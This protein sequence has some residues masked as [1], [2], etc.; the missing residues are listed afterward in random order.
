MMGRGESSNYRQNIRSYNSMFA[1]TSMGGHIDHEINRQGGGPYVFRMNGQNYHQIGTLL[2]KEGHYP[3]FAQLYIYDTENEVKNRLHASTSKTNNQQLDENIV[4]GLLEMLDEN[5]V[6]VKTFRMARDRFKEA[7]FQNVQIR[8]L[9]ER[10]RDGRRY[11]LPTTSEVAA[12]ILGQQTDEASERDIIVEHKDKQ[13]QRISELHPSFMSMQYPLLFPYGE[14]GF[15]A[16]IPYEQKKGRAGKRKYVTMLEYYCCRIQQRLNQST[17]LLR[18]G[19]LFLQFIVDAAACIEQWRLN[20]YRMHQGTLRTEL[21]SGLQDAMDNGD[22][23]TDQVGKKIILPSSYTNSP[24]N[25]QQY[26]QDAMAICRWAGYPDLFITFTCNPKWPEIQYMM[27]YI[28]EQKLEDRPD[29]CNRVFHI[30]L[31]QL[32]TK[33]IKKNMCFGRT[34]AVVYTVELQKRGL[35]H[36]HI[37]VFLDP[38]DRDASPSNIDRIISAE[39]P[40]INEDPEGYTAVEN[41]MMHGPCG[42]ANH[43]SPCMIDGKCSKH[44]PKLFSQETTIDEEGY[45]VYRRRDDSRTVEKDGVRLDNRYVVPYNRNLIVKYQA[46]INVEWCNKSRSIKYLFKYIHKGDDRTTAKL[47]ATDKNDEIQMYLDA[48]Y[49]SAGEASWRIFGFELQHREPSVQRL[50]F[51]L[52]NEQVVVFPDSTDLEQIVYKPGIET[53]I[54]TEWMTANR[55]YLH[56]RDLTYAEFPTKWTWHQKEKEW[57]PRSGGKRSIGRIYYAHPASG[58]RYY[59]RILL[60]MMKGCKS[61]KDIRTVNGVVHQTYKSACYALGLLD[62]DKEWDDCIKEASYWAS[63]AQMRQL[64]CTILLFCEVLDTGKLRESNWELLSED[65]QR[66]QRRI[67]NFETLKLQPDQVRNL[68]LIEIESLLRKGGKSLKDFH[69]MQLPDNTVMQGLRNRLLNEE[70]NYDRCSLEKECKKLIEKLNLDQRK[71]FDAITQ[72]VNSKLGKLIFVNGHGG[73][74]KTFLWKAITTSLRSE[75]KI[76]LAIASS[77]IAALLLPGGRTAHSR[78]H[79]PLNINSE[80]TCDIKQ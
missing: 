65:I 21:Y 72:S 54:F 15:R 79:I 28:P 50:Q 61:F 1:F 2:P 78:F 58:D 49:L 75:G 59:M 57:R 5:N 43:K 6:L 37:L 70:L 63:A 44:F 23:R 41:F 3:K 77:G 32:I 29:I 62:D 39:I 40:D 55:L 47:T 17:L 73:T 8:L 56:A 76:V 42:E 20:W 22:T 60:N 9:G 10:S 30:K 14:D 7:D 27:D 33:D 38:D 74:G 11:N 64:F 13:L 36:A 68:T 48:R 31:H 34:V 71:A 18:S 26:Y 16:E 19:R 25:K 51:H 67:L 45:P 35:P 24:R 53:T 80:S 66:N 12:I 4:S 46:H 52:E 69:G